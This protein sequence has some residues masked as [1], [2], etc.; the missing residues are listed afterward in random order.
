MS[1]LIKGKGY[2]AL[3]IRYKGKKIK[4]VRIALQAFN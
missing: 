2:K 1:K 4:V 3:S